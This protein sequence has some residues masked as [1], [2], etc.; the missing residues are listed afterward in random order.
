MT[1]T[2]LQ[3]NNKEIDIGQVWMYL[4]IVTYKKYVD[5]HYVTINLPGN[6]I[7]L[8]YKYSLK[9]RRVVNYSA[10]NVALSKKTN[11]KSHKIH[12]CDINKKL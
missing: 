12:K 7:K 6:V 8:T 3:A 4:G 9:W 10:N 1:C 2:N 5:R 11:C